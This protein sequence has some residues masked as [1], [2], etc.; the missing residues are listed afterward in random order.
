MSEKKL[1]EELRHCL[2]DDVCGDCKYHEPET[3]TT[4]RGLLQKAYEAVKRY[5]EMFPF[6]IGDMVFVDSKTLPTENMDFD[7][8]E[9]IPKYF[10][11]RVVSIRKNCNGKFVKLAVRAD[12]YYEWIDP[13][14]GH[15]CSYYNTEKYFTYP[16]SALGKTVFL[17]RESAEKALKEMEDRKSV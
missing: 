14:C 11:S 8:D 10:K 12:W 6:K 3:K 13:E 4:C 5:E 9:K 17:T 16:F 15:D 7:E 1:S 2:E